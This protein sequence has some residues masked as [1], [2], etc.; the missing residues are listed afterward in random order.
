MC[1]FDDYKPR[2]EILRSPCLYDVSKEG[3]GQLDLDEVL[4]FSTLKYP[5]PS[6][7]ALDSL[8]PDISH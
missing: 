6:P 5:Q 1:K 4:S 7:V 8:P 3:W 2:Y